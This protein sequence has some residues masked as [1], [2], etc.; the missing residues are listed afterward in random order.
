MY[1]RF[2]LSITE[3]FILEGILEKVEREAVEIDLTKILK[4]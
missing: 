3:G 2:T 4:A 1:D